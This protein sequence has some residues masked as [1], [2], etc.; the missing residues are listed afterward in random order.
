L[1]KLAHARR[2][3]PVNERRTLSA[4]DTAEGCAEFARGAAPREDPL[5]FSMYT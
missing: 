5:P 2:V 1:C 3:P 4:E